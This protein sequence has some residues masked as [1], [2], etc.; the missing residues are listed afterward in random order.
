[1]S[2][3]KEDKMAPK[4]KFTREEMIAAALKLFAETVPVH[5]RPRLSQ[6]NWASP[7]GLSLPALAL[8]IR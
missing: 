1:M 4:N 8:W 6:M 7:Q 3:G 5:S 2:N